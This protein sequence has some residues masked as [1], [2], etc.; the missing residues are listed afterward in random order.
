MR[1]RQNLFVNTAPAI[2]K[3]FSKNNLTASRL[4]GDMKQN[5]KHPFEKPLS[6]KPVLRGHFYCSPAC[7]SSCTKAEYDRAVKMA[8]ETIKRLKTRGWVAQLWENCGWHFCIKNTMCGM[9]V[10][11]ESN[12]NKFWCMMDYGDAK[13]TSTG[14]TCWSNNATSYA[15]PNKAVADM[16]KRA[17]VVCEAFA[18]GQENLKSIFTGAS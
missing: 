4:H 9:S 17:M 18:R 15:D 6:W 14:S 12:T 8:G 13:N 5:K 11:Y 16:S 1:G 10:H 7:G 2:I 3:T